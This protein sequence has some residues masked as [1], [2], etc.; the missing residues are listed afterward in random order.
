MS[1]T[2]AKVDAIVRM[3]GDPGLQVDVLAIM[4]PDLWHNWMIT[5]FGALSKYTEPHE[6][7]EFL[8]RFSCILEQRVGTGVW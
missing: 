8:K 4:P 5:A 6:Y 7:E 3:T 1:T 2:D